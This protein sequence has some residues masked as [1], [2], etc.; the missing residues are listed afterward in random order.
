LAR[1]EF[2]PPAKNADS[3]ERIEA[4][5]DK[6]FLPFDLNGHSG[7]VVD[8]VFKSGTSMNETARA[9]RVAGAVSVNGIVTVRTMKAR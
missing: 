9:A 1:T 4:I 2:R 3:T 6:F 7:L 5:K 8:D